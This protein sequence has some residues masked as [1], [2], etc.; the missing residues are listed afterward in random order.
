V[1]ESPKK[2]SKR[3]AK[4]VEAKEEEEEVPT[5]KRR[6]HPGTVT[7]RKHRGLQK[8]KKLVTPRETF[9]RLCRYYA[10]KMM[11]GFKGMRNGVSQIWNAQVEQQFTKFAEHARSSAKNQTLM[12]GDLTREFEKYPFTHLFKLQSLE[13]SQLYG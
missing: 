2:R 13:D 7:R 1:K 11:P 4:E 9:A 10:K 5:K 12:P 8:S 3:L 6:N